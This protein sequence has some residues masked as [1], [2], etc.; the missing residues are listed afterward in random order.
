[1][2]ECQQDHRGVALPMPVGLGRLNESLDL[3]FGQVF[4]RP[5]RG[6]WDAPGWDC[7]NNSA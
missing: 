2:P 1:M 5:Q 3:G 7:P 6:I 4:P